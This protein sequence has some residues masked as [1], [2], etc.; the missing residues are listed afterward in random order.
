MTTPLNTNTNTTTSLPK[1][2]PLP[3][4]EN[5]V[6]LDILTKRID[7]AFTQ[8]IGVLNKLMLETGLS[9]VNPKERLSQTQELGIKMEL[10]EQRCDDLYSLLEYNKQL[11]KLKILTTQNV[12]GGSSL[13][14]ISKLDQQLSDGI[15]LRKIVEEF[16]GELCLT[17]LV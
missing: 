10:F 4:N 5:T 3:R 7:E 9:D 6:K 15:Q 16:C 13:D 14:N 2:V 11:S 1:Q 8:I 12:E 17:K